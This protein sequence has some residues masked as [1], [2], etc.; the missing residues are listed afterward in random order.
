VGWLKSFWESLNDETLANF[1]PRA[2]Q[3]LAQLEDAG[4]VEVVGQRNGARGRPR[5]VY[6][7]KSEAAQ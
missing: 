5:K 6:G 3:V 4:F 2:Q 7:L 1:S